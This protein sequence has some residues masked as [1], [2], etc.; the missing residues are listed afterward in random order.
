MVRD[1]TCIYVY[2]QL[3]IPFPQTYPHAV[4]QY[5]CRILDSFYTVATDPITTLFN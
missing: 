5:K 2:S 3:T 4:V 1:H